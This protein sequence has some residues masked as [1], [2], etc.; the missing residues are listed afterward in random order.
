VGVSGKLAVVGARYEDGGPGD[1]YSQA[2][3]A[4]LFQE[5]PGPG[6]IQVRKLMATDA[7]A[8]QSFGNSVAISG[9]VVLVGAPADHGG[10][11]DPL[12]YAGAAYVFMRHLGGT[13]RWGQA[14]KL[15]APDAQAFDD[16]GFNVALS[17]KN[18]IVGA[19][20]EDGG[21]GD[22][23]TDAGAAYIF[24]MSLLEAFKAN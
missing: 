8:D 17:G 4:Y 5:L 22:P 23:I 1:P 6:W 12:S 14:R 18:A 7:N 2:G 20:S 9:G 24:Y 3:A 10:P 13:N 16:F 19:I 21:A 11:G 15:M